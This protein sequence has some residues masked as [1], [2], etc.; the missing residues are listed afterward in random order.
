VHLPPH[1]LWFWLILAVPLV[2][3]LALWLVS[4]NPNVSL[5]PLKPWLWAGC[6]LLFVPYLL[7]DIV[8]SGTNRALRLVVGT[9]LWS[10][11]GMAFWIQR[12]YMF[13]TMRS[14]NATWFSR[15][16]AEFTVPSRSLRILVRNIDSVSPWYIE[17]LGLRK[18]AQAPP[19]EPSAAILR[20]KADGNS[21]ILTTRSGFQTARTPILFTRKIDK[22]REVMSSR[23]VDPGPVERDRQGIRFFQIQ[24]PEGNAIEIV[25]G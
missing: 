25:E 13:E 4:R 14:P 23:G 19:A 3:F 8:P 20:F 1:P 16:R 10:C 24:D 11:W 6:L 2:S 12:H 15:R 22:M 21:I 17:K 9:V 18:L 7:L 5:K